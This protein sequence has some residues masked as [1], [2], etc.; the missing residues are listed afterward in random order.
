MK[1]KFALNLSLVLATL[2]LGLQPLSQAAAEKAEK[3]VSTKPAAGER[4]D[5]IR[6]RMQKMAKE[7][8]LTDAQKEQL[9]PIIKAEVAKLKELRN[10]KALSRK[11]KQEK[12]KAI[13]LEMAPQIKAV[14]TPEQFEKWQKTTKERRE[15]LK[16]Q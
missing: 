2:I 10:D 3:S 8:K 13:R 9:K 16:K 14:L 4:G 6:Q 1:N 15:R 5:A 7:L 11:E 12:M